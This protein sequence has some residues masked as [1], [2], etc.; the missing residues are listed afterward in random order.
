MLA[1]STDL[2]LAMLWDIN[3]FSWHNVIRH[4]E[5]DLNEIVINNRYKATV[6]YSRGL[7]V[8]DYL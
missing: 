3:T 6:S 2:G 5:T 1:Q 4:E 8:Y 7:N